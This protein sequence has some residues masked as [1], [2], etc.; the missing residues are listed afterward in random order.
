MKLKKKKNP[1]SAG[2][3]VDA[4]YRNTGK[5]EKLGEPWHKYD[6]SIDNKEADALGYYPDERGHRDDRVK[7]FAHPTHPS[8]GIWNEDGT[9]FNLSDLG[10][11]SPNHTL[12]GLVDNDQDPQAV[13]TYNGGVVLPEITVTPKGNYIY[14]AYNNIKLYPRK[15]QYGGIPKIPYY[16]KKYGINGQKLLDMFNALRA[17]GASNQVAFEASWQAM[18]ERPKAFYS[19]GHNEPDATSWAKNVFQHQLKRDTYKGA[20]DAKNFEEWRNATFKYNTKPTYTD[21]LRTG[22]DDGKTFVNQY[23][24]DNNLGEPIVLNNSI[25]NHKV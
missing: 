15:F 4:I 10:M 16:F 14:D 25:D 22:R 13:M 12:F 1:Y 7:K 24:Q 9:I 3:L 23:I 19:F 17:Q 20:A 21:W 2:S 8:R 11:G 18:K 5:D 6:V